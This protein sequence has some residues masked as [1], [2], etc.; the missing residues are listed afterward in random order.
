MF[1]QNAIKVF[2]R[3]SAAA[4]YAHRRHHAGRAVVRSAA[5]PLWRDAALGALHARGVDE[6]RDPLRRNFGMFNHA[7]GR[8]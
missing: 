2:C 5:G 6:N 1:S 7:G 8:L 4:F 3:I